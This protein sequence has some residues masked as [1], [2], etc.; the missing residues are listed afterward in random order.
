MSAKRTVMIALGVWAVAWLI[1]SLRGAPDPQRTNALQPRAAPETRDP[2][3]AATDVSHAPVLSRETKL[4]EFGSDAEQQPLAFAQQADTSPA[5]GRD[6]D[7]CK[8]KHIV[9]ISVCKHR[10]EPRDPNWAPQAEQRIRDFVADTGLLLMLAEDDPL[11]HFECRAT[12]CQAR[13]RVDRARLADHLRS[14]GRYPEK[15]SLSRDHE[16]AH[17]TLLGAATPNGQQSTSWAADRAEELRLGLISS[18]LLE[19]HAVVK[20]TLH[21]PAYREQDA[22]LLFE[23]SRCRALNDLCAAQ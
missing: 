6:F 10:F 14:V 12:F 18:G 1:V 3:A 15:A 22:F 9:A 7:E 2:P 8:S 13:L 5:W 21:E 23:V 20:V 17:L 19:Q 11:Y 16:L 4:G